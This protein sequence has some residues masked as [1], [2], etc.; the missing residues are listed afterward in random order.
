[1]SKYIL[2]TDRV[3]LFQHNHSKICQRAREIGNDSIFVTVVTLQEQLQG[4]LA[5]IHK[6]SANKNKKPELLSVAYHNLRKTQEFFCNLQLLD[7]DDA[8]NTYY[9]NLRQ[10]KVSVGT[11]D[12]RIAA[13]ALVNQAVVAVRNK[14]DFS[15]FP[16]LP[17]E[18]W[19][20]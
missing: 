8:A 13:I 18:D 6:L 2:D 14:K 11:H 7:F 12:L 15:K 5:T 4:R 3:T 10:Q 20:L 16:N 1:M 17:L 19:S 9:Q